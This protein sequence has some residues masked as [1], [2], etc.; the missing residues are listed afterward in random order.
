M[1]YLEFLNRVGTDI[2]G[3]PG[4]AAG[5]GE[6][7]LVIIVS[8]EREVVKDARLAMVAQQTEAAVPG[9]AGSKESKLIRA[10]AVD[11]QVVYGCAVHQSRFIG[12]G[13][14]DSG[15]GSDVHDFADCAGFDLEP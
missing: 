5:F 13:R 6:V 7:G 8:F 9:D 4:A 1:G 2:A 10:P 12:F 15:S 14:I 11:R 3:Y